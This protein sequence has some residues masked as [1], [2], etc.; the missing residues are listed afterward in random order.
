MFLLQYSLEVKLDER[1]RLEKTLK[2]KQSSTRFISFAKIKGRGSEGD[3]GRRRVEDLRDGIRLVPAGER[4]TVNGGTEKVNNFKNISKL[5]YFCNIKGWAWVKNNQ[6]ERWGNS[7]KKW[8]NSSVKIRYLR[9][10]RCLY[11]IYLI[12]KVF[13]KNL[14]RRLEEREGTRWNEKNIELKFTNSRKEKPR[15]QRLLILRSWLVF[16]LNLKR[17]CLFWPAESVGPGSRW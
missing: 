7:K 15:P 4:Q 17:N 12:W 14:P 6:R 1:L 3:E 8:R 9:P 2:V 16:L 11:K 13:G 10:E 5:E